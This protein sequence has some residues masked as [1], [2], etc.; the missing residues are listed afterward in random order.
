MGRSLMKKVK[1]KII[2][3]IMTFITIFGIA[4]KLKIVAA[5]ATVP[6]T[7]EV[8]NFVPD[9]LNLDGLVE[10][11]N[12]SDGTNGSTL[13]TNYPTNI[14]QM[15]SSDNGDQQVSSFWGKKY[16]D[17]DGTQLYNSFR[18]DKPQTISV[19]LYMGDT[20]H[21]YPDLSNSE[22]KLEAYESTKNT[23]K[24][25]DGIALVLQDDSRGAKAISTAID[26]SGKGQPSSGETLGVWAGSSADHNPL[27]VDNVLGYPADNLYNNLYTTAIQQSFAL[28]LDAVQ[29]Y[30]PTTLALDGLVYQKLVGTDDYFDENSDV[31]GQHISPG[32]PAATDTYNSNNV[33]YNFS[34]RAFYFGQKHGALGKANNVDLTGYP[35]TGNNI[36]EAWKHLTF[37][38]YPPASSDST[39]A[40]FKYSFNDQKRDGTAT[41]FNVKNSGSGEIDLT[42]FADG[43]NK[44]SN[45]IRWGFT[46]AT[47]SQYSAPK[48]Y[49]I[50]MQQMPNTA[51]VDTTAKL[52]DMSQYDSNGEL[53]REI[54]DLYQNTSFD[55]DSKDPLASLKKNSKYNVSNNDKLLFQYDLEY[56]SG[57]M[58]TGDIKTKIHLPDTYVKFSPGLS[59]TVGSNSIGKVV[60]SGEGSDVSKSHDIL[61]SDI[62]TDSDGKNVLNLQFE[63]L[64]TEGEHIT[65]FLYG[66]A[67]STTTPQLVDGT[68]TSYRSNNFIADVTTPAF[69]INDQLQLSTEK[70][71]QNVTAKTDNTISTTVDGTL[72]Y[73]NGSVF[74][75]NGVTLHMKVNGKDIGTSEANTTSG[76]KD[77]NYTIGIDGALGSDTGLKVGDN[78]IEVYGVDSLNRTSNTVTYTIHVKDYK[79]LQLTAT[80]SSQTIKTS[81]E[82]KL[83]SELTYSNGD[84]VKLSGLSIHYKIDDGEFTTAT[85]IG[86]S[87]ITKPV[88]LHM[89]L[90]AGS[91]PIGKHTIIVYTS[92]SIRNSNQVEYQVTVVNRELALTPE[93]TEQTVHDNKNVNLKGSY[94]YKDQSDFTN[95]VTSVKY[96]ITDADGNKQPEVTQDVNNKETNQTDFDIELEP[97]GAKLLDDNGQETVE[98][99]LK[100]A[101]GLKVGRNEIT[102]TAYDDDVAS[103]VATYVVNV[104]DITPSIETTKTDL[105]AIANI[106]VR[107]PMTFTYPS[108]SD[109]YGLQAKDLAVFAKEKGSTEPPVLDV[110]DR[111]EENDGQVSTPYKL[112]P[113][114]NWTKLKSGDYD[115]Q[116]Y[117]MDRYLRQT[118]TVDYQLKVLPT[119]AQVVVDNYRFETI[120]PQGKE[121]PQYVKRAGNWDIQVD[122]YDSKWSLRAK[123]DNMKRQDESGNYTEDSDLE[124]VQVNDNN[125]MPI[126]L[127]RNPVI[128]NGDSTDS[129]KPVSYSIFGDNSDPN[130]G[131]LLETGGVP[132]A[133]EYQS[134]VTWSINDTL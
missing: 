40:T 5:G 120:N 69:I 90:P 18:L 11:P 58:D 20:Y 92:D 48:T 95:K 53:G 134:S 131:I 132:L 109:D 127:S 29:N 128:A 89:E 33:T 82:I 42:K 94:A 61:A 79:D 121:V 1:L 104:P 75:G 39:K 30:T 66:Q 34:K 72:K 7:E 98:N 35:D 107:L 85:N 111:P 10:N 78:K 57:T 74:D 113:E 83:T 117:V 110:T 102:V 93:N 103:N 17:E 27:V 105:T 62:T 91:L 86:G 45:N 28:E 108:D 129:S 112:N 52:F 130:K 44:I 125:G 80:N 116:A 24:T 2:L 8:Y 3:L 26:G 114:T 65:V 51:N 32:Y 119:G 47:G 73:A 16:K 59:N 15:L 101:T 64:E 126:S 133:G 38:Y 115:L 13:I 106:P 49:S 31:K 124:M 63:N 87:A 14:M 68:P 25:S 76:S 100:S 41:A 4:N 37:K 122:S 55:P 6:T 22:K 21:R 99:Y 23:N 12:Y 19:W 81:D 77:G 123:S 60:Y 71:E 88:Q 97:I 67:N 54:S 50:V 84:D 56:K 46:A 36:N 9:G 118:N 70:S 96:Q 43:N